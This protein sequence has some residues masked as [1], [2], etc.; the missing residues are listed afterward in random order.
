M[1]DSIKIPP[2]PAP[3]T[4]ERIAHSSTTT[5]GPFLGFVQGLV[6]NKL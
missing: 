1:M 2:H 5:A 6:E 4:R 3:R